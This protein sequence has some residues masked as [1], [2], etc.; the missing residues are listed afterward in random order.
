M[1]EVSAKKAAVTDYPIHELLSQRWSPYVFDSRS[2]PKADLLSLFEAA[3]WAPSSFNEQPWRYIVTSQEDPE[4]LKEA[5]SVLSPGNA[6]ATKAPVLICTVAQLTFARNGKPNRHA[7]HDV[8][9]ASENLLLQATALG[10]LDQA[11]QLLERA[12]ALNR[13]DALMWN[14]LGVVLIRRGERR[15]GIEAFQRSLSLDSRHAGTHRNLAVALDQDGQVRMAATHY[16]AVLAL[17][18]HHPE[19]TEIE[20]R[21]ASSTDVEA[22]P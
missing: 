13:N 6:C 10:S 9:A 22:R 11:E 1:K 19:R 8:G 14:D 4:R 7:F 21:L 18:P 15:R 20:R 17:A 3:R 2:V 5:Q 16:R 12:L